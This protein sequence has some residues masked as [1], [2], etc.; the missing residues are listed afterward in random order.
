[1]FVRSQ[2]SI[3]ST[4][5][6]TN[7][8]I[9]FSHVINGRT[10]TFTEYSHAFGYPG[11]LLNIGITRNA[12]ITL[13]LPSYSKV[14]SSQAGGATAGTSDTEFRY[15][16]LLYADPK[17][18]ILGGVLAT[19]YAPTGSPGLTASSPSYELNPL[20]N[21]A[22]N[23]ARTI[24]ENLSFPL[25]NEPTTASNGKTQRSWSFA[26]QAVTFWRSPGGTLL[27]FIVQYSFS[28]STAVV[29]LNTAQLLARNFQL[30]ATYGGNNSPVDFDNP[31]EHIGRITGTAYHR[32]FTV[33][34][35]YLV[36][37]SEPLSR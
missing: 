20:L 9:V 23:K 26:P 37:R 28:T 6:G 33:G 3:Q 35:S 17:R 22:L 18:G 5:S 13:V 19:Y 14:E 1:M 12:Q 32:S 36:G 31:V 34:F 4:Y 21:L 15:K 11:A 10:V 7:V 8:P 16:A 27:A 24:G 29:T 30:Q 25:T 2:A